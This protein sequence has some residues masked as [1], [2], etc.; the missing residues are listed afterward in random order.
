[1]CWVEEGELSS[2][3]F[4]RL[5]KKR[6]ADSQISALLLDN[7]TIVSSPEELCQSVCSFYLSIFSRSGSR[8][9]CAGYSSSV[10]IRSN[11]RIK[12]LS[13]PGHSKA[14][15]PI[16]Q[17]A[18]KTSLVVITDDSIV[19][20]FETDGLYERGSAFKVNLSKSKAL[21]LGLW[22]G[23]VN[24]PVSLDWTSSKLK[25]PVFLLVLAIWRTPT[26]D[27]GFR[28]WKLSCVPEGST[29]SLSKGVLL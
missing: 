8:C 4:F 15:S 5:E 6:G 18:D 28:L 12:G 24:S 13:L 20:C 1:M 10:N 17:Y 22:R 19:A 29:F 9:V 21:W 26:G 23:R 16:S 27:Q 7:G 3:F 25:L 14:L 11:P 2:A